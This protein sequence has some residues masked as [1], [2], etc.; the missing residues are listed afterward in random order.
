ML[1]HTT[2]KIEIGK[3]AIQLA[4]VFLPKIKLFA[5][6]YG[7]KHAMMYV[8]D[9]IRKHKYRRFY[10]EIKISTVRISKKMKKYEGFVVIK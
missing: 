3:N 9:L 2:S 6:I 4:F 1:L 7:I 5:H 8:K 10:N